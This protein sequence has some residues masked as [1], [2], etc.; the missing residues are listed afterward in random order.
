MHIYSDL[1]A[2]TLSLWDRADGTV[3]F[4]SGERLFLR[5]LLSW[6]PLSRMPSQ[7]ANVNSLYF[8]MM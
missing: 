2:D 7:K 3:L 8:E 1:K 4:G 5:T 6:F